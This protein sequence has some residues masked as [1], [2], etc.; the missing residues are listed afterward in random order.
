[1]VK[2]LVLAFQTDIKLRK[3]L[4]SFKV[5]KNSLPVIRKGVLRLIKLLVY[6]I[7]ALVESGATIGLL[8]SQL[9]A[10]L[11]S[12]KLAKGPLTLYSPGE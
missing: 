6:Q 7:T 8:A 2:F 11:N 4:L 9:N 10:S 5:K 3:L 1:M 12:V